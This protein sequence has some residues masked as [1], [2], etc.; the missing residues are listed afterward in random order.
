LFGMVTGLANMR[1]RIQTLRSH[2]EGSQIVLWHSLSEWPLL[3]LE[4]NIF[5]QKEIELRNA[6][7][8]LF[9]SHLEQL[10]AKAF[11]ERVSANEPTNL[12]ELLALLKEAST[13]PSPDPSAIEARFQRARTAAQLKYHSEVL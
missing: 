1:D 12:F 13:I 4:A 8:R 6:T 3:V 10:E 2:L 5:S 9:E 11:A 7:Q